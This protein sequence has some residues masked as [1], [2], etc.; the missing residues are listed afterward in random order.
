MDIVNLMTQPAV[1]MAGEARRVVSIG[2][3]DLRIPAAA[4]NG[5]MSVWESLAGPQE[6]PPMH[7]HTFEDEAFYVLDG[8]FQFWCGD[9]SFVGGPGT[10]MLLPRNI[11]HTYRNIGETKGRLLVV[12]TPGGFENF[13]IEIE[14]TGISA[15][16]DIAACAARYGLSF[17]PP[18][19]AAA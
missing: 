15:P 4:T 2:Q 10:T 14:R 7:I 13:F 9:E 17:V 19:A 12:A 1:S 5:K 16:A 11:P 6:G 18:K 3:I 8:T